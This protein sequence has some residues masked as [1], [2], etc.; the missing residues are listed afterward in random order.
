MKIRGWFSSD[1]SSY[2]V[3]AVCV[4]QQAIVCFLV[5]VVCFGNVLKPHIIASVL[6]KGLT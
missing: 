2:L 6:S 3:C 5:S 4:H 1:F